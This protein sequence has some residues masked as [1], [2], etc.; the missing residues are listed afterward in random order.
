VTYS[1]KTYEEG[2]SI[3]LTAGDVGELKQATTFDG[4]RKFLVRAF[5]KFQDDYADEIAEAATIFGSR[6]H[7]KDELANLAYRSVQQF[8]PEGLQSQAKTWIEAKVRDAVTNLNKAMISGEQAVNRPMLSGNR[9]SA[10]SSNVLTPVISDA[11][12]QER[13]NLVTQLKY[14][15]VGSI[16]QNDLSQAEALY[17]R[18]STASRVRDP[19]A[20]FVASKYT[21]YVESLRSRIKALQFVGKNVNW[22]DVMDSEDDE[23]G[24]EST[25]RSKKKKKPA[26]R[27]TVPQRQSRL[28][29]AIAEGMFTESDILEWFTSV[30]NEQV[31]CHDD[32]S[33]V[34]MDKD[35]ARKVVSEQKSANEEL[36]RSRLLD[37]IPK[38]A[39]TVESLVAGNKPV[40]MDNIVVHCLLEKYKTYANGYMFKGPSDQLWIGTC[41]HRYGEGNQVIECLLNVGDK[42]V[43]HRPDGAFITERVNRV[44]A[45]NDDE[46]WYSVKKPSDWAVPKIQMVRETDL[47]RLQRAIETG[48][49]LIAHMKYRVKGQ[50]TWEWCSGAGQ[51]LCCMNRNKIAYSISTT[52]GVCR[53]PVFLSSGELLCGH[54]DGR[55]TKSVPNGSICVPPPQNPNEWKVLPFNADFYEF[56]QVQAAPIEE[57]LMLTRDQSMPF[58]E[59]L[60][61]PSTE[62][63]HFLG[64]QGGGYTEETKH[65][66]LRDDKGLLGGINPGYYLMKPGTE[67][68]EREI[69]RYAEPIDVDGSQVDEPIVAHLMQL[70]DNCAMEV[71][72]YPT[73]QQ[74]VDVVAQL[75]KLDKAAGA[76]HQGTQRMMLEELG[77]GDFD[78]GVAVVGREVHDMFYTLAREQNPK[79][80]LPHGD[81]WPT[82][83]TTP[84]RV[85]ELLNMGGIW[86]VFGKKD[87]YKKSKLHIGRTIQAPIF[88]LKVLWVV[89]L[90]SNDD[91]WIGRM[92]YGAA[93]W[94]YAGHDLDQP[95]SEPRKSVYGKA[96]AAYAF[97]MTAF[98]RRM[99]KWLMERFFLDYLPRLVQGLPLAVMHYLCTVTVHSCLR[100]SDGRCYLKHRGNPSGFMNTLRLNCYASMYCWLLCL[101]KVH[102]EQVRG[103]TARQTQKF[104]MQNY[105]VEVCGD[106]TRV[107]VLTPEAVKA[108]GDNG[109]RL[110]R[111][112]QHEMPWEMKVE[113]AVTFLPNETFV[114][115]MMRAPPMV[116][117]RFVPLRLCGRWYLFEPLVNVSRA[118][119]RWMHYENGRTA[120][121]ENELVTSAAS[122]LALLYKAWKDGYLL[123]AP[124]AGVHAC[125]GGERFGALVDKRIVTILGTNIGYVRDITMPF[126]G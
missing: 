8:V 115:K 45:C 36:V 92:Q 7:T 51:V 82:L 114:H 112:W 76:V 42:L 103:L 34:V 94:V 79:Q 57:G 91:K 109:E 126:G 32:K 121:L 61:S 119:K 9:D 72:E 95:V 27:A 80:V 77:N 81:A 31:L 106:D 60:T 3:I 116:S 33:V 1:Y 125:L 93:T 15:V 25:K 102:E 87:G 88:H 37:E 21:T 22:A 20:E 56:Q 86:S 70:Y 99:P 18:L 90:G 10:S 53:A 65:Y 108:S 26:F 101:I 84:E 120:E 39:P 105:H 122:S 29:K 35:L 117:R 11:D 110:F 59:R 12:R 78:V 98:D 73:L 118:V 97:D 85:Q 43:L 69:Q 58:E 40:V 55:G 44:H 111:F 100:L 16:T 47:P 74:F 28:G 41:R 63:L 6:T 96:L 104:I 107:W 2:P 52:Y 46:V 24:V 48:E 62:E 17:A 38:S 14:Y 50:Q 30:K 113:G 124:I 5:N 89:L 64:T 83:T 49:I 123:S 23:A 54:W 71:F 75:G 19:N 67:M 13:T 4:I 66:R 68:N